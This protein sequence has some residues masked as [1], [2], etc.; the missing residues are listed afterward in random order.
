[1]STARSPTSP[2][3]FRDDRRHAPPTVC[4]PPAAGLNSM[5]QKL[6][7]VNAAGGVTVCPGAGGVDV[8]ADKLPTRRSTTPLPQATVGPGA[9]HPLSTSPADSK[10]LAPTGLLLA[11][12]PTPAPMSRTLLASHQ[13]G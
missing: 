6:S 9:T 10:P 2:Q 8:R 4:S 5:Y 12:F 3:S 11:P 1:L 7:H 13:E